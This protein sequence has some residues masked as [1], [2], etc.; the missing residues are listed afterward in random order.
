MVKQSSI[1][2]FWITFFALLALVAIATAVFL[3]LD[4]T[5]KM[6]NMRMSVV[7]DENYYKISQE[8]TYKRALY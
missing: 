6:Q 4:G 7:T 1:K 5:A 8:N 2:T 3:G